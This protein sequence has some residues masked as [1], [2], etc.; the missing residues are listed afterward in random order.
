MLGS[1]GAGLLSAVS[2]HGLRLL[3]GALLLAAG[4]H[5][6]REAAALLREELKRALGTPSLVRETSRLSPLARARRAL[7][8]CGACDGRRR[9]LL[10]GGGG[11][12]GGA[13]DADPFAGCILE[14]ALD[15]SLRTL[16]EA[17]RNAHARAAPLRH[18]MFHG[19]PGT[20][21]T[22]AARRLAAHC[23][24]D[25]ALM[26]GGDVAPLGA[27]AV[28]E[29]NKLFAWA[30][31]SPRGVLLF[32][33]EAEACLSSRLRAA[34]AGGEDSR[35]ALA[36]LLHHTGAQSSRLMLVLATN[37]PGDIDGAVTD[38]V[39]EALF[40]PLPGKEQRVAMGRAYFFEYVTARSSLAGAPGISPAAPLPAAP[41]RAAAGLAATVAAAVR[42]FPCCCCARAQRSAASGA[43]AIA[44]DA[45]LPAL[46]A[47]SAGAVGFS[48]RQLS[49]LMLAVQAGA[50]G[51]SGGGAPTV[52]AKLMAEVLARE[53]QKLA[54]QRAAEVLG[55]PSAAG[56]GLLDT[57]G[58]GGG[59]GGAD[60]SPHRAL[61]HP[62][63]PAA[64]AA[65]AAAA[66]PSARLLPGAGGGALEAATPARSGGG[67]NLVP[68]LPAGVVPQPPTRPRPASRA[69]G[70]RARG[71]GGAGAG[72]AGG[73]GGGGGGEGSGGDSSLGS[74]EG[75][76][77][78]GGGRGGD[79]G[80]DSAS[81]ES[82][83]SAA[84]AGL[85]RTARKSRKPGAP[86]E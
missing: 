17:T 72:G 2:T 40:F 80:E 13:S 49:K 19:P 53:K 79:G 10:S 50:F 46:D 54:R 86:Q 41:G 20:G 67:L 76:P 66:Q 9:G 11:G 31:A 5:A 60:G 64:A 44:P 14:P 84:G 27:A 1:V 43:I 33:D 12:G 29:L 25:Y 16:A 70:A 75:E 82:L 26:S 28:H 58:D 21:K 61:Q 78:A 15:A 39:D 68:Q 52:T 4:V 59:G 73:G 34:E 81:V 37:R 45:T 7:L 63:P 56:A 6:A 47:L 38:R 23:G 18:A 62:P 36:A 77:R 48:G 42:G 69:R 74:L 83:G 8:C 22:M 35:N 30:A 65:A 3:A 85:R 55:G 57:S 71:D 24:L 51:G 32:I